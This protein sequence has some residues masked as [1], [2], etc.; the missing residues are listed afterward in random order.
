M[1]R[2][3]TIAYP[4]STRLLFHDVDRP[5]KSVQS[6]EKQAHYTW[7]LPRLTRRF[8]SVLGRQE[9]ARDTRVSGKEESGFE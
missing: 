3:A 1:R 6:G 4:S 5:L 9:D 7:H 8:V 2:R